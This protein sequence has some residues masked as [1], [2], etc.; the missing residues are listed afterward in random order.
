MY[1]FFLP[2]IVLDVCVYDLLQ[3]ILFFRTSAGGCPFKVRLSTSNDGQALVVK[4]ICHDH[5]H[6]PGKVGGRS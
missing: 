2:V 5:N 6:E 3:Q 4:E 1:F